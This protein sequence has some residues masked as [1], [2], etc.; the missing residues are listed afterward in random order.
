[1]DFMLLFKTP[2][3]IIGIGLILSFAFPSTPTMLLPRFWVIYL[4]IL[5][6]AGVSTFLVVRN[7]EGGDMLDGDPVFAYH[8]INSINKNLFQSYLI[9]LIS[10]F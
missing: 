5:V 6:A 9:K 2:A 3:V 1:M 8:H 7:S 4:C 10:W